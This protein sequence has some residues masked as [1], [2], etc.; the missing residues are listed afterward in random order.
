MNEKIQQ[1]K[2]AI[3][4]RPNVG[5][6]TLFNRLVGKRKA[7]ESETPGT[8]RDR[9]YDE[10]LW[11]GKKFTLIDT[12]GLMD[13]N[14]I[15]EIKELTEISINIAIDQADVIVFLVD[16]QEILIEDKEIA[17]RIRKSGKR[18]LLV[19]NKADN[20]NREVPSREI[21]SLGF[22]QPLFVSAI[23]GRGI[24]DFL[25]IL[26]ESFPKKII[27]NPDKNAINIAIVGRPNVGKSTLL[28][29]FVGEE[30][31]IVSNIPGTTRDTND[32]LLVYNNQKLLFVDT[33]GIRRRGK[34]EKGIEK[35][36]VIRTYGA[37]DSSEIIVILID[38]NDG[39][40]NQDAHLIGHAKDQGK[41]IIIAVN[42]F[43]IWDN[44]NAE[45]IK[46][47]MAKT[48]AI[49]QK[50]LAFVPFVPIIFLSAKTG[51]NQKVLLNK[52][53]EVYKQRFVEVDKNEIKNI[54][55]SALERNSQV[56]K[57]FDFYQERTNPVVFKLVCRNK[58]LFHFS[59]LRFLE[60]IIRDHYPFVGTPIFIDLIDLKVK[61]K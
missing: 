60:N 45:E 18:T 55:N 56:P 26:T 17:K 30:K 39:V 54:I 4:G 49:L 27:S 15:K 47:K 21:L 61:K 19:A 14:S 11:L 3:I 23:S 8:T 38:A 29:S 59:H 48:L 50:E 6:S 34:V 7:I 42:K 52:I 35:Y 58:E 24:G 33:A 57:I 46:E 53:I 12:A 31:A 41:S 44:K 32:S 20:S 1:P 40:T 51:K 28:N 2:V 22:G 9:I 37:I 16:T 10:V 25:D 43:D 13:K 5:K 36:S